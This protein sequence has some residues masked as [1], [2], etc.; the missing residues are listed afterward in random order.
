[1]FMLFKVIIKYYIFRTEW[2]DHYSK[3]VLLC[4]DIKSRKVTSDFEFFNPM[5]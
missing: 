5:F 1:M 3:T 4:C 2:V